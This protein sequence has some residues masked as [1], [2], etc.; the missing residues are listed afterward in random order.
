MARILPDMEESV[1]QKPFSAKSSNISSETPPIT[2][3][4]SQR[5]NRMPLHPLLKKHNILNIFVDI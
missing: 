5:P 1:E 4:G 2:N 3:F